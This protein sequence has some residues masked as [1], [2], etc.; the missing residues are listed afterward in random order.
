[1]KTECTNREFIV[2]YTYR[3]L[4]YGH[5]NFNVYLHAYIFAE[6]KLHSMQFSITFSVYILE[7]GSLNELDVH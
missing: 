7:I 1:M 6:N 3:Y 2:V 5:V 4:F